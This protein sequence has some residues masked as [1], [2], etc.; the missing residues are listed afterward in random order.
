[1]RQRVP[2]AVEHGEC[3]PWI[4]VEQIPL[5]GVSH[6][7]VLASG[8]DQGRAGVRRALLGTGAEQPVFADPLE[9]GLV[10]QADG[11]DHVLPVSLQRGLRLHDKVV[12]KYALLGRAERLARIDRGVQ[13][14]VRGQ[15]P[16]VLAERTDQREPGHLFRAPA[17]DGS[18][19][20]CAGGMADEQ[21]RSG[22]DHAVD[23]R[24]QEVE[25]VVSA[26]ERVRRRRVP[27]ARQVWIDPPVIMRVAEHRIDSADHLSVIDA[28]TVQHQDRGPVAVLDVMHW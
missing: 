3:G 23:E 8:D 14:L 2:G 16:D 24:E 28:R 1:V 25:N 11:G 21:E 27:H 15:I 10:G 12:A 9:A 4:V 20:V 13:D 22:A 17:G 6:R 18:G 26:V 19:V 5:A 7:G